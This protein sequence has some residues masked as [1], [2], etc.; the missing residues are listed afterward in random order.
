MFRKLARLNHIRVFASTFGASTSTIRYSYSLQCF[1]PAHLLIWTSAP[2]RR[3]V[4]RGYDVVLS[5]R[6]NTR[7]GEENMNRHAVSRL[8]E[9]A[10]LG[11]PPS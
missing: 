9:C 3:G 10:M 5:S 1:V 2:T 6:L 4:L 8:D 11:T 7:Q